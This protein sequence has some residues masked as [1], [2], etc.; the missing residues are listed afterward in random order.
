[1]TH[2]P[3]SC[4]S[5]SVSSIRRLFG[6]GRPSSLTATAPASRSAARSVR[7]SP[8]SPQVIAATGQTR[9]FAAFAR[10]RISAT[11]SGLSQ[12]GLVL[13][14]QATA[15]KPPAAAQPVKISSLWVKP[16]SRR[17]T[18]I[19]TSPGARQ[20]PVASS[21]SQSPEWA[22]TVPAAAITPFST[23]RS[24][25]WSVPLDGSIN[26]AC[27][28]HSLFIVS[29]TQK[30]PPIKEMGRRFIKGEKQNRKPDPLE[31]KTDSSVCRAYLTSPSSFSV[32]IIIQYFFRFVYPAKS[33][34]FV[35][36]DVFFYPKSQ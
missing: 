29:Q 4:A 15:V 7:C 5:R 19:S 11:T 1:M 14:M 13:G 28:I 30:C 18:C 9:A 35:D 21:V 27:L 34:F 31:Y 12:A 17:C 25:I 20:R 33:S 10:P 16:G 36:F 22:G 6:T 32:W 26:R 8:R 23:R 24:P 2:R 3:C